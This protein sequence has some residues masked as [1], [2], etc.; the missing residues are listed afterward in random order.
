MNKNE[1]KNKNK[2]ENN[3]THIGVFQILT[4]I[5]PNNDIDELFHTH[6]ILSEIAQAI[7]SSLL[8]F[9][10]EKKNEKISTETEEFSEFFKKMKNKYS[11]KIEKLHRKCEIWK[12]VSENSFVLLRAASCVGDLSFQ[13]AVQLAKNSTYLIEDEKNVLKNSKKEI[14][15][16]KIDNI[17]ENKNI[18]DKKNDHNIIANKEII[19]KIQIN[20]KDNDITEERTEALLLMKFILEKSKKF[21]S[22]IIENS[23]K[24]VN[25]ENFDFFT[26][27]M[28]VLIHHLIYFKVISFLFLYLFTYFF[29]FIYLLI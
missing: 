7:T 13:E 26:D 2:N 9:F 4:K 18:N 29:L 15:K 6:E 17:N 11:E 16:N 5:D 8:I 12:S 23:T 3:S 14:N 27:F 20:L 1:S 10:S 19:D 25:I 24:T 22:L 28:F 21:H